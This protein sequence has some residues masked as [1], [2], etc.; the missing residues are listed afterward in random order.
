MSYKI[1]YSNNPHAHCK[2]NPLD[3]SIKHIQ[4][5]TA[6]PKYHQAWDRIFKGKRKRNEKSKNDG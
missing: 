3:T 5:K 6:T 2:F 4:S 1:H